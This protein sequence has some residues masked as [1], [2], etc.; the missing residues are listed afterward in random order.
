MSCALLRGPTGFQFYPG[1]AQISFQSPVTLTFYSLDWPVFSC[2]QQTINGTEYS[3]CRPAIRQ[4]PTGDQTFRVL[5]GSSNADVLFR[6]N[7]P[8]IVSVTPNPGYAGQQLVLSIDSL[9]PGFAVVY[10]GTH[11]TGPVSSQQVSTCWSRCAD[12]SVVSG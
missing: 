2:S 10:F 5:V 4:N 8:T 11:T 7:P 1:V 3:T 12:Q 9:C 6:Y